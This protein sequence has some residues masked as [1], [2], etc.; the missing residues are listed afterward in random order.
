[1]E[2]NSG[3]GGAAPA[4][5]V[6]V[7]NYPQAWTEKVGAF[8]EAIGM[9]LEDTTTRLRKLVG[10]AT[11]ANLAI[12]ADEGNAPFEDFAGEFGGVPK[13]KLRAAVKALR[14]AVKP[15]APATPAT[16]GAASATMLNLLP[17][18]PDDTA[19]TAMLKVGGVLRVG[20]TEVIAAIRASLASR[21]GLFEL[22]R[23]LVDRM[24]EFADQQGEPCGADFYV[25]QRLLTRR[26]YAEIFAALEIEGGRV[27]TDAR[28]KALL[29]KMDAIWDSLSGF[30][31]QVVGWYESWMKGAANPGII[32]AAFAAMAG[33]GSTGLPQGIM[34]PPDTAV[35]RDAAEAFADAVNKVFA[36][37]GI[38]IARA[39]AYDAA[40]I[41]EMLERPTIP[42]LV[43]ATS[44]DQMLK[45]LGVNVS[46]D[47]VRLEQNVTRYALAIMKYPTI[48]AWN[49]EYAYLTAMFQLG[50]SIPWDKLQNEGGRS[51]IGIIGEGAPRR[52]NT[53][54]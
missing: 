17:A 2:T 24:E 30:Q 15:P 26:S 20:E 9:S 40:Q 51:G 41:K 22:P 47:Y 36:G 10:D 16:G 3:T 44:R 50:N 53:Q 8:A 23:V 4:A 21:T 52:R 49:E 25:L 18:V 14:A 1:M 6:V 37:M 43:G 31:R 33:S 29:G 7:A 35:L 46:A 27:V 19:F 42:A 48:G 54:L 38:P 45:M 39:M 5:E 12:L 13:P 32:F 28:K 11:D 34:Q